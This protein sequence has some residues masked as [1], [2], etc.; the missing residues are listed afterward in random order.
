MA[1]VGHAARF[2]LRLISCYVAGVLAEFVTMPYLLGWGLEMQNVV[3]AWVLGVVLFMLLAI[4]GG[5]IWRR[6][7][8]ARP[9]RSAM[10]APA[11]LMLAIYFLLR[12]LSGFEPGEARFALEAAIVGGLCAL[13]SSAFFA[14][15]TAIAP[16]AASAE[17]SGAKSK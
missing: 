5:L 6:A 3:L 2:Q 13:F 12:A 9:L 15:W 4:P 11:I 1:G 7:I 17:G 16:G 14:L 10:A 8:R